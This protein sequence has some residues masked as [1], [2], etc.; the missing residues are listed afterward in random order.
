MSRN[1]DDL[2]YEYR[3]RLAPADDARCASCRHS[4]GDMR[5]PAAS[6][7]LLG[8]VIANT[9]TSACPAQEPRLDTA[10]AEEKP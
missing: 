1:I 5:A 9:R 10:A 2:R 3:F 7:S 6:C 4:R 8:I